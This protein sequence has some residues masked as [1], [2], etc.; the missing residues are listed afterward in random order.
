MNTP[1]I[2]CPF[3]LALAA[4]PAAQ[5]VHAY[6]TG[7][8]GTGGLVPVLWAND[9]MRIG[10]TSF[11]YTIERALPLAAAV[12]SLAFAP[13][14]ITVVGLSV[15]VDPLQSMTLPVVT[16]DA[17][18]RASIPL[19]INANPAFLGLELFAQFYV[20]DQGSAARIPLSSS[21]GLRTRIARSALLAV[22][23][24]SG[25]QTVIELAT[26]TIHNFGAG[27]ITLGE[28]AAF[29][30]D[31]THLFITSLTNNRVAV[32][33]ARVLPPTHV[34]NIST[35]AQAYH[36]NLSPDGTR[37]Y[38][39]C[40]SSQTIPNGFIEV[41]DANP[42]SANF[43]NRWAGG[44]PNPIPLGPIGDGL[45]LLF[46]TDGR[47][48]YFIN[49][50]TR[51]GSRLYREFDT[52]PT[53]PSLHTEL[54][55]LNPVGPVWAFSHAVARDGARAFLAL[56]GLNGPAEIAVLDLNAWV[57][58]DMDSGAP[59][60]QN[61]GGEL[62][63][64]RTNI[65]AN[66]TGLAVDP[67]GRYLYMAE[68]TS[69]AR[70]DVDPNSANYRSVMRPPGTTASSIDQVEVTAAGEMVYFGVGSGTIL[71]YMAE[72]FA[73]ARQFTVLSPAKGLGAR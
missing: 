5:A 54:R 48:S 13:A 68:R 55:A 25:P 35:A 1:R 22:V 28:D 72:P 3:V 41:L 49:L 65:A 56:R 46:S 70:L 44:G 7:T 19:P 10:S 11:R 64:P 43:G 32:F 23:Q 38:V 31:G 24:G 71:E 12:P 73:P 39:T 15:L 30:R 34:R 20:L 60:I 47:R 52:D 18:G 61:L 50:G 69:L 26:G 27:Q 63:I 36:L 40:W 9:T 45:S 37:M 51:G 2:V 4:A 66:V 6:G 62:S 8:A 42:N 14:Q 33:D 67:R 53:S 58:L 17:S 59:G 57:Q 29:T 21:N 16:T